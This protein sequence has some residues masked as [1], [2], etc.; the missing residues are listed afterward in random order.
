MNPSRDLIVEALILHDEPEVLETIPRRL[1]KSKF[2]TCIPWVLRWT[3]DGH[4]AY[5]E[6]L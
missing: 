6:L 3:F 1:E 2:A 4:L 5:F